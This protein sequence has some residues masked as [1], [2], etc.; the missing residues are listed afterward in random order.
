[1]KILFSFLP[2]YIA[3]MEPI[4]LL[5]AV[6]TVAYFINAR[7]QKRRIA[8]LQSYL[9]QQNIEKLM[10]DLTQG[11]MRALGEADLE[12]QNQIWNLLATSEQTLSTQFKLL[13][14][15]FAPVD[16]ARARVSKLPFSIPFANQLFPATTFDLRKLLSIHAHGI[17]NAADNVLDQ[18][19]KNKAFTMT[20]E[21]FLMQHTCHWFCRS[22]TVASARLLARHK[23]SYAQLLAAVAPAT[24]KA[25]GALT[26]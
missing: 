18:S 12:R 2:F 24:G 8:L 1:L 10:E 14:K 7:D 3:A 13:A 17:A 16:E 25:Y 22:K 21:L 4:S 19:P 9:G 23:T 20:S 26:A 6:A 11:Y 15:A 5:M